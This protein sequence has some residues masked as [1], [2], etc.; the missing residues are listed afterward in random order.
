MALEIGVSSGFVAVAPTDDPVGG[1]LLIV[2]VRGSVS[3]DTSPPNAAKVT[4]VGWWCDNDTIEGNF[5]VGLYAA[6]GID[7]VAGTLL[8]VSRTNTKTTGAGWKT[9]TVDW[10]IDSDTAYWIAFQ[11]GPTTSSLSNNETSGGTGY[12]RED[13]TTLNNPFGGGDLADVDGMMSIYAVW[14]TLPPFKFIGT[15][16][17]IDSVEQDKPKQMSVER[18]I[19]EFNGTSHFAVEFDN[20]DGRFSDTFNLNDEVVIYADEDTNSPTTKLF[21]GIIEDINFSGKPKKEKLVLSGRDFGA[22]LQDVTIQP[23]VFSNRDAGEIAKI[24]VEQNVKSLVT[25]NNIDTSTGT[26]ITRIS[27][28]QKNVFDALT[29]LAELAGFYFYVDEDKDVH[30]E[31]KSGISSGKTFNNTNVTKSTFKTVDSEIFNQVWVYG[32]RTLVG[33]NATTGIG[34]GSV[35][36]L[37]DKP[38]NTRVSVGSTLQQDGGV[39]NLNEPNTESGLKYLVDFNSREIIF[40]SGIAAGDNIP[41]SGESNV[42]IDYEKSVP[43]IKFDSDSDSIGSFGPKTKI[44]TDR[45]IKNQTEA[46][47]KATQFLADNKDPK[48]QGKISVKGVINITPGNTAVVNIPFHNIYSQTYTILN[49]KYSF[50]KINN[51]SSQVLELSLNKKIADFTDIMKDQ[52]LRVKELETG[53]LEG[54]LAFLQINEGSVGVQVSGWEVR[55]RTLGSSFILGHPINTGSTGPIYGGVLG[56][57]VASGINFLG[58]SKSAFTIQQSGGV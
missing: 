20:Y 56:S 9:A 55:T 14:E 49:A 33:A 31:V 48:T 7:D 54:T 18:S 26:T 30:F 5:E 37:S 29:Q 38:H 4:E 11:L 41:S 23:T 51:E 28:N 43:I 44:I 32:D 47:D 27:F 24:I 39:L 2:D 45:N 52:M 19:G 50:N 34:A 13:A 35:I 36:T 57:V 40:V 8:Q 58:D 12:D 16:L 6:D 1:G 25:L 53:P 46:E 15:K 17:E 21:T 3:H 10:D 42:S 22:V